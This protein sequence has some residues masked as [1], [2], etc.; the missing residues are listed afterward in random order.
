M[1]FSQWQIPDISPLEIAGMAFL[2]HH[3]IGIRIYLC[4]N[5]LK[6]ITKIDQF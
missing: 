4:I 3:E 1:N 2:L 5:M 6:C